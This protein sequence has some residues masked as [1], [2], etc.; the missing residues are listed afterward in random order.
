[1]AKQPTR[2][3]VIAKAESFGD[4]T[5][6]DINPQQVVFRFQTAD[7]YKSFREWVTDAGLSYTYSGRYL[8]ASVF[9]F[10]PNFGE[11][12]VKVKDAQTGDAV[13]P[14][15]AKAPM[16]MPPANAMSMVRPPAD[17]KAIG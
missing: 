7:A 5:T 11:S 14:D 13:S 10:A 6:F 3:E 2:T 12:L 8:T 17:A 9:T 1:M 4:V 15:V 16:M